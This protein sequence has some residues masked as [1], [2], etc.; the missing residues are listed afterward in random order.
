[1]IQKIEELERLFKKKNLSEVTKEEMES[2]IKDLEIIYDKAKELERK[3]QLLKAKYDNDAKY[4]RL[5]KR[6]TKKIL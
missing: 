2:N 5:H 3:N 1:M 6:L 4:A